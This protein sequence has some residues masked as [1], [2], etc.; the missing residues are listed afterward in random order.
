MVCVSVY[1]GILIV[2]TGGASALDVGLPATAN[3]FSRSSIRFK[4][5]STNK[6]FGVVTDGGG[7]G[8]ISPDDNGCVG[9]GAAPASLEQPIPETD[10]FL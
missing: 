10:F 2:F 9:V 8:P 5:V 6:G 1:S 7:S 4:R 3:L